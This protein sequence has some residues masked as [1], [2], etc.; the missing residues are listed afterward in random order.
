MNTHSIDDVVAMFGGGS[1]WW[2]REGMR[3][4][5]FPYLKVGRERR[6]TDA[7]LGAIAAALETQARPQQA[8]Q[9]AD[10]AVFGATARSQKLHRNRADSRA[11]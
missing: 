2:L 1:D 6:F 8:N 5:R 7:H 3:T 4:G 9:P 10:V 11:S